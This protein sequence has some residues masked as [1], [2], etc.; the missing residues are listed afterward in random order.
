[1]AIAD[2]PLGVVSPTPGFA[3]DIEGAPKSL[4]VGN[5]GT[6]KAK[7]SG[8]PVDSDTEHEA[9]STSTDEGEQLAD[10]VAGS[11]RKIAAWREFADSLPKLETEEDRKKRERR[12]KSKRIIAAVSDGIGALSNIFFT[13][14]YAPNMYNHEQSSQTNAVNARI[15][16]MKAERERAREAHMKYSLG[17]G[18]AENERAKTVRELEAQRERMKLAREKAQQ[19]EDAAKRAAAL[20]PDQKREQKGKADRAEQD[21]ITAQAQAENAP[22]L[23]AAKLDTEMSRADAQRASAANSR[24]SARAHDK[25]NEAEKPYAYDKRGKKHYFEKESTAERFARS[26]GTWESYDVQTD[27]ETDSQIDGKTTKTK[28]TPNGYSKKPKLRESPTGR[29]S[30]TANHNN[31]FQWTK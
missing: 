26:E 22:A 15:E 11:D 2:K 12:E 17:L 4:P 8:T 9:P 1:M 29:K 18:D 21:A 20:F 6:D 19:E 27:E 25:S 3:T 7:I 24:A 16:R 31:L 28:W 5:D 30:P 13:T 23:Q 14:Q 10:A